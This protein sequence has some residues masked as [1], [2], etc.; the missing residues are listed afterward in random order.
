M[1]WDINPFAPRSPI[2]L[3]ESAVFAAANGTVVPVPVD[4]EGLVVAARGRKDRPVPQLVYVTPSHQCPLGITMSLSRRLELLDFAAR[5][6][7]WIVEDDYDSE[8]RYFSR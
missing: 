4:A 7:A 1:R 5:T 6:G 2:T 3:R 8:Y